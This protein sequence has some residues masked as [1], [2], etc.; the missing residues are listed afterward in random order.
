MLHHRGHFGPLISA[1]APGEGN[2]TP[3]YD[4]AA[5]KVKCGVQTYKRNSFVCYFVKFKNPNVVSFTQ[6]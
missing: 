2:M 6:A 4:I 5:V 3:K 1:A